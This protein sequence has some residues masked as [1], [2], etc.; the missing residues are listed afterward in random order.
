MAQAVADPFGYVRLWSQARNETGWWHTFEL[1]NGVVIQGATTL[2]AQRTRLARFPIPADLTGKRVLDVGTWD[3]WFAMEM[4]RRGAEVVAIDRW[5]NPRFHVIRELSGSRVDYRQLSVYDL[6]PN[7][8]GR[9]DIVLFL[10]VLYHL[11]HPLLA[12]EK[13]ASVAT[14]LVAVESFVLREHHRPGLGIEDRTLM[15]FYETDE[16]GGE[17]DNWVG[18]T[19]PC[20][21]ALCRAAGFARVDLNVVH[22]FG[23]SISCHRTWDSTQ[24]STAGAGSSLTLGRVFNA[25][26][27]GIN[28]NASSSDDYVACRVK[29]EGIGWTRDTVRPEVA[30]YGAR[31]LFIGSVK[32]E[33]QIIFKLPPG[34]PAGWHPVRVVTPQAASNTLPIAVDVPLMAGSLAINGI[35]DG[36]TWEPHRVSLKNGVVAIWVDGLPENADIANVGVYVGGRRQLTTFVGRLAP[37]AATQVNAAVDP[38]IPLGTQRLS[39]RVAGIETTEPVEITD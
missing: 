19:V 8:I 23:A 31:P 20:L 30:G 9:F 4:E 11:K 37:H 1:P 12:L 29:P 6:D 24:A 14:G 36:V 5:D 39:I 10:G 16:M 21:L 3:G 27:F 26:T 33:C 35:C 25:E 18:P 2:A 38:A 7:R 17:F 28:F 34:L 32:D 15:E 22:E 13:V